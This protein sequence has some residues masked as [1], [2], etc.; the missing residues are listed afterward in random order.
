MKLLALLPGG[1][2]RVEVMAV[3]KTTNWL[4]IYYFFVKNWGI[5]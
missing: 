2:C 1:L 4:Q 3:A 5:C